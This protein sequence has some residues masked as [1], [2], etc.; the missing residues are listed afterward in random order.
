MSTSQHLAAQ[1]RDFAALHVPG[2]PL[3]LPN[4]W[5]A[6]SAAV[7]AEA[8]AAAVATSSSGVSW[9]L[10][11]PDGN[12]LPREEGLAAIARIASVVEVPVTADIEN[13]YAR[14]A[15]GVA[16]TVAGVLD[17][18]AIGINIEDGDRDPDDLVARI[19]AARAAAEAAGVPLFVNARTDVF[20]AEL[21]PPENR[22]DESLA[23]AAAYLAAGADGIFVPGVVDL[24]VVTRLVA[25]IEAPVNVLAGAGAP[26]TAEFAGVGV[27]RVSLGGA[28]AGSAYARVRAVTREALTTGT[29]SGLTDVVSH[30]EMDGLVSRRA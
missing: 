25:G 16:E 6:A 4:A 3:V 22:V 1:A 30:G 12:V 5:D 20:L 11:R 29:Y 21:V 23:R 14:N 2:R 9:S 27:A 26:D 24:D 28:V 10:G 8:G 19:R 15:A 18:G 17:A 7:I 13:G